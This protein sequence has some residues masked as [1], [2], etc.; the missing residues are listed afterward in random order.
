MKF[1]IFYSWQSDR[2]G[3]LCKNF[4]EV[5]LSDA[6]A[7]LS[8]KRN[9]EIAVD[10]D[11]EGVPGTP[12]IAATIL[13]KIE[14]CDVFLADVSFVAITDG[15]KLI[16]NPNV[17]GEFGFALKAK[18]WKRI[19]LAMNTTYGEPA[20]LP[21]D[22]RHCRFPATYQLA[23]EK[24]DADRRNKRAQFSAQLEWKIEAILDDFLANSAPPPNLRQSLEEI[25]YATQNAWVSNNPPVLVSQ[26]SARVYMVPVAAIDAPSLDLRTV[27]SLRHLLAPIDDQG[28]EF[29]Q[30]HTQWWA[31]GPTRRFVEK[32]NPEAQWSGRLL[33]SGVIEHIFNI[34]QPHAGDRETLVNGLTFEREIVTR[35]DRSL[36]MFEALGLY[37]PTLISVALY[38]LD[39]VYLT[40]APHARR[41]KTP[42]LQLQSAMVP[43]R[44]RQSGNVLRQTFD[45][46][47]L[48]AGRC[49]G[50][51]SF[52]GSDEWAGYASDAV[53]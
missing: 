12:P 2:P 6:A 48:A 27:N 28:A 29:G 42:S 23:T 43:E 15:G 49:D 33:R 52:A 26:P 17:M 35:A 10:S 11:T 41:F 18:G 30:D 32:P 14:A 16:P 39:S 7:R 19:L 45:D 8:A 1:T 22:L 47:W 3:K 46:L 40:G 13:E 9:V 5:A 34:G 20:E 31:H 36:E 21:F 37:G 38:D 53:D 50:S 44:G 25:R 4:I 24:P 51:L